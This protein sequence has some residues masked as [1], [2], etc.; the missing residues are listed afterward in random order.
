MSRI[1]RAGLGAEGATDQRFLTNIIRRTFLELLQD[2]TY[3]VDILDASWLG[4][5]K[6][7]DEVLACILKAEA[8]NLDIICLHTGSDNR[9]RKEAFEKSI[10][11]GFN[12]W[13]A[14]ALEVVP[15]IPT[16]ETEAW[17]L[18]DPHAICALIGTNKSPAQLGFHGDPEKTNDPKSKL[19]K[20]L[21]TA[22]LDTAGFPHMTR[23]ELYEP[24]G[25]RIGLEA[26]K[27]L[28]SYNEFYQQAKK[29][30]M[31][32]NFLH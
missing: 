25:L 30:L 31:R 10:L 32:L 29:A 22:F 28:D 12:A 8:D 1:F 26:L 15:I 3:E 24:L 23:F 20:G 21:Q 11:P 6:G 7:K 17:M 13:Q 27:K 4:I 16:S 19:D 18:A 5:A 2:A 14:S 9:S